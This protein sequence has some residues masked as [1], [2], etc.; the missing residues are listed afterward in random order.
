MLSLESPRNH[1]L[2]MPPRAFDEAFWET[3]RSGVE[4]P[5][6]QS[7]GDSEPPSSAPK[8]CETGLA[9]P[10]LTSV[11]SSSSS[12]FSF[13]LPL[14]M[15]AH[16]RWRKAASVSSDAE[17]RESDF[18]SWR[19]AKP[20]YRI[21]DVAFGYGSKSSSSSCSSSTSASA[22]VALKL[23]VGMSGVSRFGTRRVTCGVKYAL[24]SVGR[25]AQVIGRDEDPSAASASAAASAEQAARGEAA[26]LASI[27][28]DWDGRAALEAVAEQAC[29]GGSQSAGRSSSSG[30]VVVGGVFSATTRGDWER[31]AQS[32]KRHTRNVGPGSHDPRV[33]LIKRSVAAVKFSTSTKSC[34]VVEAVGEPAQ[35][36]PIP[37]AF[38]ADP[39]RGPSLGSR[40]AAPR[41]TN[42]DTP[43]PV[44]NLPSAKARSAH[45]G[46]DL[47]ERRRI[48]RLLERRSQSAS[49][50]TGE[51]DSDTA[52]SSVGCDSDRGSGGGSRLGDSRH[53][54]VGFGFGCDF[55]QHAR[56]GRCLDGNC[57]R[58]ADWERTNNE[59]A[60]ADTLRRAQSKDPGVPS[61]RRLNS[62]SLHALTLSRE[63]A[64]A[65]IFA[66]K[67]NNARVLQEIL[68]PRKD[69]ET[70]LEVPP[71]DVDAAEAGTGRTA[72]HIASDRGYM[73]I[74]NMLLAAGADVSRRDAGG[75]C[76]LHLAARSGHDRVVERLVECGADPMA[77]CVD[78]ESGSVLL[79]ID[80][81]KTP[82][83]FGLFR[84]HQLI[85]ATGEKLATARSRR[86]QMEAARAARSTKPRGSELEK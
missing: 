42:A 15:Q 51:C 79:P 68:A 40:A 49:G 5:V 45:I 44:Y 69:P 50:G 74:V 34:P 22:P 11:V 8:D 48:E 65:L 7:G 24:P 20:W 30:A 83:A 78:P 3:W 36:A 37:T 57:S 66:V 28:F 29:I 55:E 6:G 10:S 59:L 31:V 43:G 35:A 81:A 19:Y 17:S 77:R 12:A 21:T 80:V 56:Y 1:P 84:T 46:P 13:P 4:R 63:A 33:S 16:P 67:D 62:H 72:L 47:S 86:R 41:S 9:Q 60:M 27:P 58:R 75:W 54:F 76:A 32:G 38:G 2:K 61:T 53:E 14:A 64:P 26:G 25:G 70:G 85:A 82:F 18:A 71:P 39:R 52:D 73:R 23:G